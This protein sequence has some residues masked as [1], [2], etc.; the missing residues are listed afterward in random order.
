MYEDCPSGINNFKFSE[1]SFPFFII[2][3]SFNFN[4]KRNNS[5]FS[6]LK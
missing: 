5:S 6:L 3:A 4:A 1:I 2:Y